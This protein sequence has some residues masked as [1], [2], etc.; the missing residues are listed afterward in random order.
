MKIILFIFQGTWWNSYWRNPKWKVNGLIFSSALFEKKFSDDVQ[1]PAHSKYKMPKTLIS[2]M[3]WDFSLSFRWYLLPARL[4]PI[5]YINRSLKNAPKWIWEGK[6]WNWE[7][8]N[9]V[10]YPVQLSFAVPNVLF[11][12]FVHKINVWI[13]LVPGPRQNLSSRDHVCVLVYTVFHRFFQAV[14]NYQLLLFV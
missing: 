1:K 12:V 2:W 5:L 4:W 7:I 6:S 10:P 14:P 3:R 11:V 8:S 9:A 13:Q